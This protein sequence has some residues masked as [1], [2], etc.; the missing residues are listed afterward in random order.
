MN[1][2]ILFEKTTCSHD[3]PMTHDLVNV[4]TNRIV[5]TM[6]AECARE[7]PSHADLKVQARLFSAGGRVE[8]TVWKRAPYPPRQ[9]PNVFRDVS[10]FVEKFLSEDQLSS[11]VWQQRVDHMR[12]EWEEYVEASM[13]DD[14]AGAF[15]ALIDLVYLALGTACLHRFDFYEGWRR[16][17]A[18]NMKKVKGGP[19]RVAKPAGWTPPDLSDLIKEKE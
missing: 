11:E 2:R 10:D 15:D 7:T 9:P 3:G 16:V 19:K 8:R 5:V 6:C 13:K 14:Q 18:A 12:E 4:R 1:N 17:H